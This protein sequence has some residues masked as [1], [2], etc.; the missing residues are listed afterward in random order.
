MILKCFL[1]RISGS[2]R[3]SPGSRYVSVLSCCEHGGNISGSVT[4]GFFISR[5]VT[6]SFS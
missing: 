5:C 2:E 3:D 4:A 1:Q 6:I